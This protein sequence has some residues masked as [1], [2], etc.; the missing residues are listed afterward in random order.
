MARNKYPEETIQRILDVSFKLFM[1]KGY[2]TTSIQDILKELGGLTKGAIY[3]HFKSKEDILLAVS[4]RIYSE[5]N[6]IMQ[7]VV[8][9]TSLNGLQKLQKLFRIAL[10][11]VGQEDMMMMAPKLLDNPTSLVLHLHNSIEEAVPQF[12]RPILEE[13]IRDGSIQTEY[14]A[15]LA[16]LL[17]LL[18]NMWLNPMIFST[19][20]TSLLNR[21][22]L[23]QKLLMGLGLDL[24]DDGMMACLESYAVLYE[25][26]SEEKYKK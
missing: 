24:F 7:A 8:H 15:E 25:K 2:E 9:D 16:E 1:E 5:T 21:C 4:H 13:G 12:I 17:M 3:H 26:Q 20:P 14:P 19:T 22:R 11:Q 6:A 23:F 18:P 10:S